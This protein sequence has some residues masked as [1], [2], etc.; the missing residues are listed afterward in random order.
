VPD[1]RY[2]CISDLHLGASNS[3]LTHLDAA[4]AHAAGPAPLLEAVL[5][6]LRALVASSGTP[7]PPTLVIHGDLFE[8]ALTSVEVAAASFAEM[9]LIG[10]GDASGPLF[11]AEAVFVPGNH[12]HHM[13]ELMREHDFEADLGSTLA[14]L[15]P[16]R[17]VTPMLPGPRRSQDREPLVEALARLALAGRDVAAPSFQV[18]YPNLGLVDA[19]GQRAVVV[20]HGH[21]LEPMYRAMSYLHDVVN[22]S[23]PSELTAD[24]VEADNWAWI[25]FFWST[26]GRSG[27][28]GDAEVPVLYELMRTESAVDAIV[29]RALDDV[30][31]RTR[32]PI[33]AAERLVLRRV[34]QRAVGHVERR[35]RL[36]PGLLSPQATLGLDTYLA[37]PVQRQL[38]AEVGHVPARV[39]LVFGHTHKPFATASRHTGYVEK[40][41]THNTGGWVVDS[42]EPEPVKGA[43]ITLI[44]DELEVVDLCVYRQHAG[45]RRPPV[46]VM[47]VPGAPDEP[48]PLRDWLVAEL[49]ARP[50]PWT[51]TASVAA[52]TVHER[53][54][55][56]EAR[57]RLG[58][59]AAR[60]AAATGPLGW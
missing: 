36:R 35:E 12:D 32:S 31:P 58:T 34:A 44:S 4:G 52:D 42:V 25:D 21:Y 54:R 8:M 14:G 27:E 3:V 41:I 19:T 38:Q 48:T 47:A 10:W 6:G 29:D 56:L 5:D 30:L 37:G 53:Q 15:K 23:R 26:M 43:A 60:G 39:D 16:M 55:Q 40:V 59:D 2:V 57:V 28:A 7:T 33:R 13:W 9:V 49:D 50:D 20:T 46:T 51:R 45:A 17:H 24:E 22:P 11:A 1:I 18:V